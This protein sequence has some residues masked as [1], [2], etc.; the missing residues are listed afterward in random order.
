MLKIE[1]DVIVNEH[2][3]EQCILKFCQIF[4]KVWKNVYIL[5]ERSQKSV[6]IVINGLLFA[7]SLSYYMSFSPGS[8][9]KF[10]KRSVGLLVAWPPPT[11]ASKKRLFFLDVYFCAS[12]LCAQTMLLLLLNGMYAHRNN[13]EIMIQ[14][15]CI[16]IAIIQ[17]SIKMMACRM[18]R[19]S[20][21]SIVTE[22][23]SIVKLAAPHEKA[24]LQ[25]Y[26]KR[27]AILH[28]F[29]T[30][31]FYLAGTNIVLGPIFL[32]QSLPTFAVYPFDA[33][34]HPTYEIVYIQQAFTCIQA[35]TG[36]TIDCQ[37]A[38]LLWFAGARFEMLTIEI[39]NT[40]DE[41]DLNR[42]I[43]KHR[44]LLSY[45]EKVVK[46]V[47]FVILA[48]VGITTI[49]VVFS[50][51]L[52]LFSDSI[53]VK[54]QFLVL[55]IV[56]II[57]LFLNSY[58]AE[59]L[60]EMSSAIGLAAYDL[61]WVDKSRKMWKNLC[62]L[63][64]RSQKPVTVRIAGFLPDLSLTYYMF[65][66][67]TALK[68][69]KRSVDLLVV[70][71]PPMNT[72]KTKLFLLDVYFWV[73]FICAQILL[74]L[75]LNGI[76]AHRDNFEI[77]IESTCVAI[78]IIQMSIK[79]M[80]CR[81]QR[82]SFQSIVREMESIVKLAAPHEKA[83]LQKYVNRSAILHIFLTFGFYLASTNVVLGPIFLP[84]SLPTFAVYPFDA[85]SHPVYEIVYFTQVVTGVQASTGATIDCQV[86]LLLW[87]AGA[88]FEMLTIE[89]ANTVDEYDLNRC[90]EK[91]RQILSYAEKVVKTVRFVILAT[92][93]ITTILVVFSGLLLLF[94][95]SITVKFQFLVLD[96]VA[97]IQ[98]F[99]NSYPA[100]N[101]IEMS[102][103]I[104]LA[105]YDLNWVD[106]SRKMWKNLCILI[107]R[108]QKPVT[109]RIAGFLPDLSLTYYMSYFFR[110]NDPSYYT[111]Q[112]IYCYISVNNDIKRNTGNCFEIYKNECYHNGLL[113][114]TI[115]R[116]KKTITLARHLLFN[117]DTY[118]VHYHRYLSNVRKDGDIEKA[119]LETSV[120]NRGNGKF[121][122]RNPLEK[123]ILQNY[124]NRCAVFHLAVTV[125]YY[126]IC[127]SLILAPTILSQPFPT[128]AK[129]PFKVDSHPIYDIVYLQQA[130]IGII[131]VVGSSIDC[132][133]AVLL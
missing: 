107:Q 118:C 73:S 74:L 124:V 110:T 68:F 86:A 119:T 71:P 114:T 78:A 15:T 5:I 12:F 132:L 45:A 62:I 50:G 51:L 106:K 20:L 11:T 13:F 32:P 95:D 27:C 84:Q 120:D 90:I 53:T 48:T 91:H 31:G 113:A 8:A 17:M 127:T 100:E 89:I 80:A 130:F 60:I 58:P 99:L 26:V 18:Q 4:R 133:V 28:V 57:Q 69:T 40:V 54:F 98:L 37:V 52:L 66:P 123:S 103:A 6:T 116:N 131:S 97:I 59:N 92:V 55:D 96:I 121:R 108:S 94:S 87:F 46:T 85:E 65:T 9:L 105:A 76:Y 24:I 14:S 115:K 111:I 77:M 126:M 33:E 49:L 43:E 19:S 36:A 16:A 125:S 21:Q 128:F 42:C 122:W 56:A 1:M 38:L 39:A 23:E 34:S 117:Y 29:L 81:M 75:L 25:K 101:L 93:G 104:G 10:T 129:Y 22:M 30:F 79:M 102:S 88:R 70:W 63:I 3:L 83:I 112:K 67:E 44:Q 61:N 2:D 72:S 41:Y 47:R 35:S 82:S 109:V 7:L 64:Q